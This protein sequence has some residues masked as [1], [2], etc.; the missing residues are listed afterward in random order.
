MGNVCVN[1]CTHIIS[2]PYSNLSDN[3]IATIEAGA[4]D[5][6]TCTDGSINLQNNLIKTIESTAL[7]LIDAENM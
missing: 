5:D 1:N 7:N 4:F 2:L 3:R 6:V